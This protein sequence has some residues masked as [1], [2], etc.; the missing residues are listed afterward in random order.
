[1]LLDMRFPRLMLLS[2]TDE[3]RRHDYDCHAVNENEN[4]M[5]I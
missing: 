3:L 2:I 5:I 4:E 1:M